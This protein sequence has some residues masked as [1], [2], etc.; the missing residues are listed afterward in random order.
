MWIDAQFEGLSFLNAVPELSQLY[1][2]N[3]QKRY[4]SYAQ[5]QGLAKKKKDDLPYKY[6]SDAEAEYWRKIRE[7]RSDK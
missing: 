4:R 7:K 1:G 6:N 5:K 3:A 2:I